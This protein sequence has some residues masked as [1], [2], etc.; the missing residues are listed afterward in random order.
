LPK[1]LRPSQ[2]D[3]DAIR[4][5]MDI[6]E[7]REYLHNKTGRFHVGDHIYVMNK[8]ALVTILPP[9]AKNGA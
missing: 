7:L 1:N 4:A 9:E 2:I 8:G 3:L 5:E 6:P